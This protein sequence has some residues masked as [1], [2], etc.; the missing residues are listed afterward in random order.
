MGSDGFPS[1]WPACSAAVYRSQ[2]AEVA[3]ERYARVHRFDLYTNLIGAHWRK[4][5]DFLLPRLGSLVPETHRQA[6]E[7]KRGEIAPKAGKKAR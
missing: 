7:S 4:G 5:G 6:G 2:T 1:R 3:S